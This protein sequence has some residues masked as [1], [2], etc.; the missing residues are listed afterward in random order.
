MPFSGSTVLAASPLHW[1][2]CRCNYKYLNAGPGAIGGFFVHRKHLNKGHG[3]GQCRRHMPVLRKDFPFW[4]GGGAWAKILHGQAVLAD[5][6][7]KP[8]AGCSLQ[9]G[10]PVG[11]R[12]HVTSPG[13][14]RVDW[15]NGVITC[16]LG[17]Q[18]HDR[19]MPE[20][21]DCPIRLFC[22][23]SRCLRV[24]NFFRGTSRFS[25]RAQALK[26]LHMP[27]RTTMSELRGRPGTGCSRAAHGVKL[28]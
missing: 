8:D 14:G 13:C 2:S 24:W 28:M 1:W 5:P 12:G 17:W 4:L 6:F 11:P 22:R 16:S 3:S 25:R 23:P 20:L 9:H 15:N 19:S 21:G 27:C 10:A 26:Y 18:L 7:V